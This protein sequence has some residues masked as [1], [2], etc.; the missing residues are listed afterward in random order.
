ME[1]SK[2]DGKLMMRVNDQ[3]EHK[4]W[5]ET[6]KEM[7]NYLQVKDRPKMQIIQN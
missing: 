1:R 2:Q 7:K 6:R 3:D 4:V 5:Y